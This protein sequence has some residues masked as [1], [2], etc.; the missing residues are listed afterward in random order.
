MK[1]IRRRPALASL[2]DK[3]SSPTTALT[4]MRLFRWRITG[5]IKSWR[6]LHVH[7][8]LSLLVAGILFDLE[9]IIDSISI[10]VILILENFFILSY[11]IVKLAIEA[12][13]CCIL[14][15]RF[16]KLFLLRSRDIQ[17]LD[18]H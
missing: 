3:L 15:F 2:V 11:N 7:L 10:G 12:I 4:A 18:R 17:I 16:E 8:I 13:I 6:I 5:R 14:L 1:F 9:L